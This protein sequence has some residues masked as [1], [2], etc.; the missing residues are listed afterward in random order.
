M[1]KIIQK[2]I[3][4][5]GGT[6]GHIYPGIAIAKKIKDLY[7]TAE[8]LFIGALGRM[9][10]QKIPESGFSIIGLDIVGIKRKFHLSNLT[11]PFKIIK[12]IYICFQILQKNNPDI[13]I[14]VGGYASGVMVFSA[15]IK[16]IPTLIQEQNSFPGIT[17][18][19][20]ANFVNTICVAYN[21]MEKY[22]PHKKIVVT[23]NPIRDNIHI[24]TDKKNIFLEKMNLSSHYPII[25][26]IG[27][28]LGA[29]TIN[30]FF[31]SN[32]E[33]ILQ[34]SIQI[35]WQTGKM[36]YTDIQNKFNHTPNKG[37]IIQ[38]F[39]NNMDEVYS[40]ADII[41]SRA[42]ALSISELCMVGKPVIFIPSPHVA[43]DH[44]TKNALILKQN[45]AALLVKDNEV[46]EKLL[47]LLLN[48]LSDEDLKNTLSQNI[49]LFAKTNATEKIVAEMMKLL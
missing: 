29:K 42:G 9:E 47:N 46:N 23:G 20:L 7:P 14:G 21:G 25:L 17:N 41:I 1:N 6:G 11:L 16:N 37:L 26:A 43:E 18:K 36:Y 19:I 35:I 30:D 3:I 48:L 2:V 38:E 27:G 31:V 33:S 22:F 34:K 44:Q 15:A 4:S 8:I 10:M 32:A 49:K 45:N 28:S 13:V 5:G 12:N 39:I 24:N 40:V